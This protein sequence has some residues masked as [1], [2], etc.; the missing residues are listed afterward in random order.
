MKRIEFRLSMPGRASW[1]GKWSGAGKHY[2]IARTM[3][4]EN[5]DKLMRGA[6]ERSWNHHWPDGWTAEVTAR[7]VPP[8]ERLKKSAGFCG[9]DWMV[10]N[11]LDHG[12]TQNAKAAGRIAP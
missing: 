5:A 12:N 9:Y 8:G 4:D 11:I 3:T 10:A 1:D 7:V 2:A 6:V